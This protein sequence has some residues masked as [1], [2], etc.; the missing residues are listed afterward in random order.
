MARVEYSRDGGVKW[1]A[2]FPVDGLADSRTERY[3]LVLEGPVGDA[4]VTLRASD[5]MN[6]ADMRMSRRC[7]DEPA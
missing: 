3:S 6:N 5:S 7:C 1:T 4:G 2:I